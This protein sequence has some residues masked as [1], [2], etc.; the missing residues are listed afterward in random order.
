MNVLFACNTPDT[1]CCPVQFSRA[2]TFN[3][4]FLCLLGIY[5]LFICKFILVAVHNQTSAM[6]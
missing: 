5:C 3:S 2:F 4:Q 1:V 6:T